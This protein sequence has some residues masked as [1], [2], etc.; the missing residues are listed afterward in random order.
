MLETIDA[1]FHQ[2]VEFVRVHETWAAP[3]VFCLAFGESDR[4]SVV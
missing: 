1:Y 2:I 3:I 4:K